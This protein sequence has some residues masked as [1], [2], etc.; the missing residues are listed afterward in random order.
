MVNME[1]RLNGG[2]DK[3]QEVAEMFSSSL[4]P[5]KIGLGN[6][7]FFSVI[8]IFITCYISGNARS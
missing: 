1:S 3:N 5:K 8:N 7:G 6:R 4:W 2:L